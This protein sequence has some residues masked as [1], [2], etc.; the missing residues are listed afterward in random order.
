LLQEA[1]GLAELVGAEG[2][3]QERRD[4]GP[5][6]VRWDQGEKIGHGGQVRKDGAEGGGAEIVMGPVGVQESGE[7]VP[8]IGPGPGAQGDGELQLDS[9]MGVIGEPQ[10]C[11]E[12]G[13][14]G[15]GLREAQ[16]MGAESR[17]GIGE[18]VEE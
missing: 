10:G 15:A 17:V 12:D 13:G 18:S 5:V 1:T 14:C 6:F 8:D 11:L 9:G 16:G 3:L 7:G 4:Q 2:R